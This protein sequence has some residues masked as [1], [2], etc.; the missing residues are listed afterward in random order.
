MM[1]TNLHEYLCFDWALISACLCIIAILVV[2]YFYFIFYD[3]VPQGKID[4]R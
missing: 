3:F 1:V 4:N 2:G